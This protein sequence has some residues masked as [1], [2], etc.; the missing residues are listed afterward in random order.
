M[1][2]ALKHNYNKTYI[3]NLSSELQKHWGAFPTAAFTKSIFDKEWKNRELKDRMLHICFQLR[4]F[5]PQ[6]YPAA[7]EIILSAAPPFNGYEALYFPQFVCEFGREKKFRKT[8]LKA[9]ATLTTYSSAEFA[10]RPFILED[11]IPETLLEQR[12]FP[13]PWSGNPL[14]IRSYTHAISV[15]YGLYHFWSQVERKGTEFPPHGPCG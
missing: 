1:A 13:S 3:K 12:I 10:I 7:L 8:S 14:D 9:L 6:N 2:E 11:E 5:L 4:Q 15:W